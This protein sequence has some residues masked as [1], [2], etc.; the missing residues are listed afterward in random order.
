MKRIVIIMSMAL[1]CL[2]GTQQQA[3]AQFIVADP[4]NM[5]TSIINT[6]TEIV[7]TSTTA[8]NVINSFKETKKIYD[9]GKEYYDGLKKVH[10]VFKDAQKVKSTILMVGEITDIYYNSYQLMIQDENFTVE[11][12]KAIAGGYAKLMEEANLVLSDLKE[13]VNEDVFSMSDRERM[14]VIDYAYERM[15]EYRNLVR[16]FTNK[17]ISVS[18]V[19]AQ[20]IKEADRIIS[21]YGSPEDRY[22]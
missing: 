15:S 11:E 18:Y 3:K 7:E 10:T 4:L 8:T 9:Q 14:Q 13:V 22:W 21:L 2:V 17:N 12:L 1:V 19:R 20:K 6:L 5:A 16:Y